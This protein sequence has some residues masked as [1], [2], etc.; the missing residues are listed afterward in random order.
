MRPAATTARKL[1]I[2]IILRISAKEAPNPADIETANKVLSHS[3]HTWIPRRFSRNILPRKDRYAIC[4][5]PRHI[6]F[7]YATAQGIP[8]S[9]PC[10]V[11]SLV[12][13]RR[14]VHGRPVRWQPLCTLQ[15]AIGF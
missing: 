3:L 9:L 1:L 10:Y 15:E 2:V 7:S 11:F 8:M 4:V 14:Y 13:S 12:K 5:R 6:I